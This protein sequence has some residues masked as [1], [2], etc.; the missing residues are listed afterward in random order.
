MNPYRISVI[1]LLIAGGV[2]LSACGDKKQPAAQQDDGKVLATVN[3][4]NITDKELT[5]YQQLR[6]SRD[7]NADPAKE[8]KA[9]LDEMVDRSLLTQ[10]AES[11]G[12]DKDPEVQYLLKRWREN[13]LVQAM[14]RQMLKDN[15]ITD[16][17]LKARFQKEVDATHKTEYRVR[18][19]LVKNE[20]EAKDVIKEL[21]SNKK[22]DFAALAKKHSIDVQSGKNGGQLGGWVNQGMV[23]PEFFTAVTHLKKGEISSEPV[24]SDFGWHVIKVDDTRP[25]QIPTFEEFMANPQTKNN[26][27]S[28]LRDEKMEQMLKDLRAKAKIE[29]KELPVDTQQTTEAQPAQSQETTETKQQ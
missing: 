26:F 7:P 12:V 4:Q 13:I 1:A 17:E 10:R 14:V 2:A 27:Y 23:V 15:P 18:H 5:H 24:K 16:D 3:G 25:A 6:P 29:L 9:V 20:D 21:K 28:K 11:T 19:I 8:K 22:A